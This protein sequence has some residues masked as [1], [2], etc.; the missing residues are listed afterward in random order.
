MLDNAQVTSALRPRSHLVVLAQCTV[1]SKAAPTT[2]GEEP[3]QHYRQG[4]KVRSTN[5]RVFLCWCILTVH[6]TLPDHFLNFSTRK[7]MKKTNWFLKKNNQ[8]LKFKMDNTT[9]LQPFSEKICSRS[10]TMLFQN[11]I[12]KTKRIFTKNG[13]QIAFFVIEF[14][15]FKLFWKHYP[16]F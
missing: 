16:K 5:L 14:F 2:R 9:T 3:K 1:P 4:E 13:L 11:L 15:N 10:R 7:I 6:K 8:C 12:I